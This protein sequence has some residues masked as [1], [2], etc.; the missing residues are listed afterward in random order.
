[1]CDPKIVAWTER[2]VFIAPD[3]FHAR[4][5]A[6]DKTNGPISGCVVHQDDF[7]ILVGLLMNRVYAGS[8]VIHAIVL[9]QDYGYKRIGHLRLSF[10]VRL[11]TMAPSTE[12]NSLPIEHP[13][14]LDLPANCLPIP[15]S[16]LHSI[17]T[18]HSSPSIRHRS[19]SPRST[20]QSQKPPS[21]R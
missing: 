17:G 8:N 20:Y 9:R 10:R 1:M 15:R 19:R 2:K 21:R 18:L 12:L 14:D 4:I 6:F 3:D 13:H 11:C 7:N 5:V 16:L